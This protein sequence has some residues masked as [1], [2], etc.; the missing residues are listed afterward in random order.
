VGGAEAQELVRVANRDGSFHVE[1]IDR[2]RFVPLIGEHG[3]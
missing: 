2:A 1:T 3:W